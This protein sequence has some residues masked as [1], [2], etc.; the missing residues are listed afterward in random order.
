MN[1][2]ADPE[3]WKTMFDEVYL[4]TDARS[5]G[6][7]EI[8]RRE[9]DLICELVP[10]DPGDRILD[11]CGGH[12]RHSLELYARGFK[13]CILLDYSEYLLA[14]ARAR[15]LDEGRPIAIIR[16]DA[17]NTGLRSGGIDH[18]LILGNSL[19]YHHDPE[20]DMRILAECRRVLAP[21]G[22]LLLDIADAEAVRE[23]F[24]PEAWHEGEAG[25]VVCRRRAM[26]E[27]TVFVRELVLSKGAGLIRD[28]T[29][30]IRVYESSE[31]ARMLDL[32]GF[33]EVRIIKDFSS[34]GTP[35]DYGFM[36]CRMVAVGRKES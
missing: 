7:D 2:Q 1:I 6:N 25:I 4:L 5:V 29:Y 18:A 12:G 11:L 20:T 15:A 16:A 31:I 26:R 13:K 3:W 28:R 27:N 35:G 17:A 9:V 14:H 22:R 33:G 10:M 19:G 24:T 23:R 34:H 8:T 21:S 36:S 32:A 30:S